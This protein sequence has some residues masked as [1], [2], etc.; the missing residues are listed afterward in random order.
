[1]TSYCIYYQAYI[2]RQKTWLLVATLRSFEHV[3]FDR[4]LSKENNQFEFFVVPS[5]ELLFLQIMEIFIK[6]GLVEDLKK[7]P[8]RYRDSINE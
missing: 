4:T 3:A 6:Q 1:M 7:L 2:D 8:N 5:Q